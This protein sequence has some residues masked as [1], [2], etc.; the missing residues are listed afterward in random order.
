MKKTLSILLVVVVLCT[1]LPFE[2]LAAKGD[3]LVALTFDD[4]PSSVLTPKLLDGLK[5]RGV[6]VT[7]SCWATG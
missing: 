6:K 1:M 4:G 2:T 3:K 5:A 7:F